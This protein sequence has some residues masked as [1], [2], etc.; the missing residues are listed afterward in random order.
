MV[1]SACPNEG[2]PEPEAGRPAVGIAGL[3]AVVIAGLPAVGFAG[4]PAGMP[5]HDP[6]RSGLSTPPGRG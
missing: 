4:V 1:W 6:A 3:P 5:H 2:P